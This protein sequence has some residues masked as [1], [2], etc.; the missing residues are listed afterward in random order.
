MSVADERI[1]RLERQVEK[2]L[3]RVEAQAAEIAVLKAENAAL[4]TENAELKR[5]LGQNSSNSNKPPSSDS[6]A[7]RDER[8]DKKL[9]SGRAPGGQ[10]G[11]KGKTRTLLP[12]SK[13]TNTTECFPETCRRCNKDLAPTPDASPIRHQVFE[14]PKDVLVD[15]FRLHTVTCS[16]GATTCAALPP[17]TPAGLF[18]P[19]LLALIAVLTGSMHVSRRKVQLLLSD[20]YGIDVS[21][22]CI[23]ESEEVV[24]EAVADAVDEALVHALAARV[25]HVDATTWYQSGMYRSLWVLA[26]KAVTVFHVAA[27]GTQQALQSWL[28]QVRGILVTDRGSQF[29]FWAMERRQI[30][31]AHLL[32]KFASYA[33]RSGRAGQLGNQL[34]LWTGIVFDHWH[35]VRDGTLS[36]AK[37]R[38]RIAPVRAFIERLLEEGAGLSGIGGSCRD[39]LAHREALWTFIDE[40]GVEPTNNHA[41]RELRGFVM[42]RKLTFGSRSV[43]GTRFAA[44]IKSVVSTCRKQGRPLFDYLTSAI[45]AALRNRRTPSLLVAA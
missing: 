12:A 5:R 22:G 44:N 11:H 8:Q 17:G 9:G 39:I 35:Q 4:K 1:E 27:N 32:R 3:A 45:Q 38:T 6:P 15:E 28:S 43:R 42:W 14:I 24:S 33:T 26:T 25:K 19:R 13:V 23:S 34:L 10:P 16:C 41:E 20:L 7:D 36:R 18:G 30:C 31:L 29:G 2:L 40:L 37:F 21:L